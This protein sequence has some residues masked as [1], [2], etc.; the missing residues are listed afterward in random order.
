[1][2]NFIDLDMARHMAE[3]SD[4]RSETNPV[5]EDGASVSHNGPMQTKSFSM[6]RKIKNAPTWKKIAATAIVIVLISVSFFTIRY[7]AG[8]LLEE[9]EVSIE[10]IRILESDQN[11]LRMEIDI[12][13]TN[14]SFITVNLDESDIDVMYQGQKAADFTL[15][16]LRLVSGENRMSIEIELRE[17]NGETLQLLADDLIS[18]KDIE[19]E[20][21]GNIKTGGWLSLELPLKRTIKLQQFQDLD[22]DIRKISIN[23]TDE[24]GIMGEVNAI[25]TNPTTIETTLEGLSFDLLYNDTILAKI[26]SSGYLARGDNELNISLFIPAQTIS[27]GRTFFSDI[28]N[29][30]DFS[31]EIKGNGSDG[32]LLSK[33]T[34]GFVHHYTDNDSLVGSFKELEIYVQNINMIETGEEGITGEVGV[35]VGN[36]SI[37]ETTLEGLTFDL[38]YDSSLLAVISATGFLERGDNS[39]NLPIFVPAQ[40]S[41]AYNS[42]VSEVMN[43]GSFNFEI[44][45]NDRSGLPLSLLSTEFHY[46][47][48]MNIS[49]GVNSSVTSLDLNPGLFTT[50][51]AITASLENPTPIS[52]DL[53]NF[54][55]TS[56]YQGSYLGNIV[57]LDPWIVPGVQTIDL[58]MTVSTISLQNLGLFLKLVSGSEIEL[59]IEGK[60]E[61]DQNNVLRFYLTTTI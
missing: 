9:S 61:F 45:G 16:S 38:F 34:A 29:G 55:L 1:M 40:S 26:S 6:V 25:V 24:E 11:M 50:K 58:E 10:G 17:H 59:L 51:L 15:P 42:L 33:L 30:N 46:D 14:P 20:L 28:M 2:N 52:I 39:L 54:Q 56:F 3:N 7:Y 5:T 35:I 41:D 4:T 47:Y 21:I 32:L 44:H 22:I 18:S 53:S 60:H 57:L 43:G 13:I 48:V 27:N 8:T 37:I 23:E 19:I 31:F 49:G 12:L 36:P